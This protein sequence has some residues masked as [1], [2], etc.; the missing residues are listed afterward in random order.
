[1]IKGGPL[2]PQLRGHEIPGVLDTL[3]EVN[4]PR[5]GKIWV[6]SLDFREEGACLD[7]SGKE[8]Q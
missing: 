6:H 8:R 7:A 4:V 2:V 1:M 3:T 5:L